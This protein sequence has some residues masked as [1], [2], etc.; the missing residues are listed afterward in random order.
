MQI[1]PIGTPANA[2]VGGFLDANTGGLVLLWSVV[3]ETSS[4]RVTYQFDPFRPSYRG[5]DDAVE[6]ALHIMASP[7][8]VGTTQRHALGDTHFGERELLKLAFNDASSTHS[9]AELPVLAPPVGTGAAISRDLGTLPGLSVPNSGDAQS[10]YAQVRP[11]T[12]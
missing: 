7:A 1:T 10:G 4:V 12:W 3:P 5:P 9:E 8:S 6:T 11:R 2:V